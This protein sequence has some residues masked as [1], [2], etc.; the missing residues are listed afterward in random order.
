MKW[1]LGILTSLGIA[2]IVVAGW[3]AGPS[4][5]LM[6]SG[7]IST[8]EIVD[9][10]I[11]PSRGSG[12]SLRAPL[13]QFRAGARIVRGQLKATSD[14]AYI[15]GD[16]V[17][18]YYAP[19]TPERFVVADFEQMWQRPVILICLALAMFAA[20]W[21]VG[22]AM[23]GVSEPVIFSL[24]FRGI[25]ALLF[26]T[27]VLTAASQW[28]ELRR[29]L[30]TV[31]T[32]ANGRG[33][34]WRLFD[35]GGNSAIPAEI[36]FVTTAGVKLTIVDIGFDARYQPPNAP[37][38]IFYNLERPHRGKVATFGTL[39]FNSILFGA[40]GLAMLSAGFAVRVFF[41]T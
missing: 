12:R 15:K 30:H 25:G 24:A 35:N 11:I 28:L 29:S 14:P 10:R 3:L 4:I 13:V 18:L 37:V 22:Q 1:A 32:I 33:E 41:R 39:W 40:F 5:V 21:L 20:A 36:S 31:G 9:I 7:A 2:L 27:A 34:P 38:H 19:A 8:G 23:R 17:Q 26:A 16:R 6:H